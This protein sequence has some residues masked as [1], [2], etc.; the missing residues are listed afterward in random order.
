MDNLLITEIAWDP[1]SDDLPT[2]LFVEKGD[3]HG[4]EGL[5]RGEQ[6]E[7][8]KKYLQDIRLVR[9]LLKTDFIHHPPPHELIHPVQVRR[10]RRPST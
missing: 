8:L 7:Y 6:Q 5:E 2:D 1:P 4:F 10:A 3:L 9:G